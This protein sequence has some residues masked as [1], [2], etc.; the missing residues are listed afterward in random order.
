MIVSWAHAR[1]VKLRLIQ[2]CKPNQN[3]YVKS[4]N[5]RLHDECLNEH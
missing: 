1:G 3:A 5:G 2:P 4:F